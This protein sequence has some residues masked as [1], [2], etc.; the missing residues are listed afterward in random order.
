MSDTDTIKL[1][2]GKRKNGHKSDCTCHICENMKAKAKRGGYQEDLE[3]EKEKQMGG[4]KKKNGHKKDCDCPICKNM[5]NKKQNEVTDKKSSHGKKKSNGHKIDCG[6]PICKNMK[7]KKGGADSEVAKDSEYDELDNIPESKSE[8]SEKDVKS[9]E[10]EKDVKSDE[11][12]PVVIKSETPPSTPV[13]S[14]PEKIGGTKKRRGTKKSNGHKLNCGC[15]IYK[16][17]KKTRRNKKRG[18]RRYFKK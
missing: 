17:M 10:S 12:E 7:K 2:G 13:E 18:T 8:K 3:K 1:K 4:S 5:K 16:N 9:D 6:C 14:I 15:P 11:S